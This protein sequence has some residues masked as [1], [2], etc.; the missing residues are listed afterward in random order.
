M[1]LQ[2][3]GVQEDVDESWDGPLSEGPWLVTGKNLKG[4]QCKGTAS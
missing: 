4:S 1:L 3:N 2:E